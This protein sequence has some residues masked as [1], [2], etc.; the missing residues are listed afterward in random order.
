[1][2]SKE[3]LAVVNLR[4]KFHTRGSYCGFVRRSSWMFKPKPSTTALLAAVAAM[5]A[6]RPESATAGV[7]SW[8]NSTTSWFTSNAWIGGVPSATQDALLPTILTTVNPILGAGTADV[9]SLAIDNS[10]GGIY[11]IGTP[12]T[13]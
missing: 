11:S 5:G 13:D 8:A 1:F 2:N 3:S 4:L 6:A 12:T 9:H 10:G 7:S